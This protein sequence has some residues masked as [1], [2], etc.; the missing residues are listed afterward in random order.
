MKD[1]A[2]SLHFSRDM[3][4]KNIEMR[5]NLNKAKRKDLGRNEK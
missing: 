4:E 5:R 1:N 3:A 2:F